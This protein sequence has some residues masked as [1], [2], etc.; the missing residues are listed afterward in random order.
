MVES[1]TQL[2][3]ELGELDV[4]DENER[5]SILECLTVSCYTLIVI[6]LLSILPPP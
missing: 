6:V 3:S 4:A 1:R 5:A 2:I